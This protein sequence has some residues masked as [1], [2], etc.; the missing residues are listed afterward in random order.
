VADVSGY[1]S[2][3]GDRAL[4]GAP[5]IVRSGGTVIISPTPTASPTGPSPTPVATTCNRAAFVTDVSI[6]DN[7]A[8]TANTPFTKTWRLKNVG[9][10]TW[11]TAYNVYFVSGS[12]M[13]APATI[14]LISTV[15]PG[16][17]VD[18]SVPMTAPN[19]AGTYQGYWKLHNA[20]G[21]S[22]G[23]G[24]TFNN[25][26]WTLIKVTTTSGGGTTTGAAFDFIAN[27]CSATW[28]SGAG[29]KRSRAETRSFMRRP[30][31][32]AV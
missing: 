28:T 17:T 1:G 30:E 6:P 21:A 24:T 31:P 13:G 18:I 29:A 8:F 23:I 19:V 32:A 2:P 15:A 12:Q 26:F 3:T 20:S 27:A 10:C 16:Q 14:N 25:P 4:W 7:T 9:T 22:F 5:K 11:T